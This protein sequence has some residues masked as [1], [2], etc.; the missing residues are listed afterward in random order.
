MRCYPIFDCE[1]AKLVGTLDDAESAV[2][3][4]IVTGGNELRSGPFSGQA[5]LA[6][7]IAAAGY[8]VF[9]FDRRGVGDSDGENGSFRQSAPDIAAALAAFREAAPQVRR[10]VALGNCDAASALMLAGGG[11]CDAL[12]LS[13]P[14][15]FEDD[16]ETAAPPP[17]AIRARYAER[18]KNPREIWRL[19]SGGVNLRKL[20]CGLIAAARAAPTPTGLLEDIRTGLASFAGETRI[21]LAGRDRTAQAFAAGWAAD[22]PRLRLREGA[23]HAFSVSEDSA[24]LKGQIL[25]ALDEQARQLDMG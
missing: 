7:Q 22:E 5:Q 24:W 13:N 15:T 16:D 9:R 12:V 25:A 17:D 1:G 10:V 8:P 2:G 18:L 23:D 14:W 4:L 6:R 21:L 3:L 20:A 11:G 19:I